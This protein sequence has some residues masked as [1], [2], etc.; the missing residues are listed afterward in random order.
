[1]KNLPQYDKG[2]HEYV[3]MELAVKAELMTKML[4]QIDKSITDAKLAGPNAVGNM[5]ISCYFNG[6][7]QLVTL[8]KEDKRSLVDS[9]YYKEKIDGMLKMIAAR[10]LAEPLFKSLMPLPLIFCSDSG[11]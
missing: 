9:L 10:E 6:E 11:C 1:M 5:Y 4:Q 3:V 2:S 8:T 7:H